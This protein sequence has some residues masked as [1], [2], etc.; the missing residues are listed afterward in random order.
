MHS[1]PTA[2]RWTKQSNL[3]QILIHQHLHSIGLQ[4]V[5]AA[6]KGVAI[7]L[8]GHPAFETYKR[9]RVYEPHSG[10]SLIRIQGVRNAIYD[11]ALETRSRLV[12]Q[13]YKCSV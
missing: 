11:R 10:S 5:P 2:P 8:P 12:T 7:H 4:H 1:F 13:R 6:F 9:G 3:R